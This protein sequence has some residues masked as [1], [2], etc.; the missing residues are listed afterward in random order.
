MRLLTNGVVFESMPESIALSLES[1]ATAV[2]LVGTSREVGE[3]EI[4]GFS[5]HTLGVKSN[6]RLK[7]MGGMPYSQYIVE[8]A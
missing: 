4:L 8:V 3:L 7:H 2:M 6:C 1:G 5:I